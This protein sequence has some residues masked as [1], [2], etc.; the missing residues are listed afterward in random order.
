MAEQYAVVYFPDATL[1]AEGV[2]PFRSYAHATAAAER[3][4]FSLDGENA[5]F[6]NDWANRVPQVVRLVSERVAIERDGI[7][8][9]TDSE[10]R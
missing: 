8:E 10:P 7:T 9:R 4:S 2:G 6:S 5:D 1:N 3:L